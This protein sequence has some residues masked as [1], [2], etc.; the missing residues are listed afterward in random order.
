MYGKRKWVLRLLVCV[1][2][3][4][5]L[6]FIWIYMPSQG[7]VTFHDQ[8]KGVTIET[9]L[10]REEMV[11]VKKILWGKVKWPEGLYGYPACGFGDIYSITLNGTCYMPAWDSCGM[12]CA[13]D[14]SFDDGH[15]SYINISLRQKQILDEIISSRGE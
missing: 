3:I 6:R 12:I 5:L 13:R 8:D 10:T 4:L 15:R 11:A 1:A 14:A 7:T 9:E 2:A